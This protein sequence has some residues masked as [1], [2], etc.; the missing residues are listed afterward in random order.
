MHQRKYRAPIVFCSNALKRNELEDIS[1]KENKLTC[2]VKGSFL[3]HGLV[4]EFWKS[5]TRCT[6]LRHT[7]FHASLPPCKC[8]HGPK[9][10]AKHTKK[11]L[12]QKFQFL[13]PLNCLYVDKWFLLI[14]GTE[15]RNF[16]TLLKENY[17]IALN[18]CYLFTHW[19]LNWTW[20]WQQ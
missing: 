18:S 8:T 15:S 13:K 6:F 2:F 19:T 10:S 4:N 20:Y 16:K 1:F 9:V 12:Y 11:K 7:V 17:A 14:W 3:V 5:I